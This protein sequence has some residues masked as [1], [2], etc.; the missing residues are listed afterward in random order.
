MIFQISNEEKI[1]FINHYS[2]TEMKLNYVASHS[3][4]A[5]S[6]LSA[7]LTELW[8]FQISNDWFNARKKI[9]GCI[10]RN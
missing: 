2:I 8:K 6:W 10:H 9:I 4:V 3:L 5:E 7:A 1:S